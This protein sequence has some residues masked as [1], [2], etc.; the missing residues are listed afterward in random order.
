VAGPYVNVG[1][2]ARYKHMAKMGTFARKHF[3][4]SGDS[5]RFCLG[6]GYMMLFASAPIDTE[7][8]RFL[9]VRDL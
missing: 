5:A 7:I 2:G 1:D 4:I 9:S 3:T 8:L 6:C